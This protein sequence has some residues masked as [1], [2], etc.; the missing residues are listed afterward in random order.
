MGVAGAAGVGLLTGLSHLPI[1]V[2]NEAKDL[3]A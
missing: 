2:R 3:P 1:E